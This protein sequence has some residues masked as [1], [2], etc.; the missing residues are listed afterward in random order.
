MYV[1]DDSVD[2]METQPPSDMEVEES[3]VRDSTPIVPNPLPS[4]GSPAR[5]TRR[6]PRA[7]RSSRADAPATDPMYRWPGLPESS[8]RRELRCWCFTAWLNGEVTDPRAF[9][10]KVED[11]I[12]QF[13]ACG[14]VTYAVMGVETCPDTQ[15]LHIQGYAE[16]ETGMRLSQ[17][18][19][20][21]DPILGQG[22]HWGERYSNQ[23]ACVE[24][25][26]KDGVYFEKGTPTRQGR[27]KAA[28]RMMDIVRGGGNMRDVLSMPD[29]SGHAW[30]QYSKGIERAMF[31]MQAPRNP[32]QSTTVIIVWGP[33][34]S[35]KSRWAFGINGVSTVGYRP[36]FF[37]GDM[38]A[39]SL[40]FDDFNPTTMEREVFLRL[41]DRYPCPAEVKGG[42][43]T[44]NARNVI[45]TSNHDPN[46]WSWHNAGCSFDDA[47]RRR[48]TKIVNLFETPMTDE[49]KKELDE[50]LK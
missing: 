4:T 43:V 47:C 35:G 19:R 14:Q 45:F 23:R 9:T 34:G 28:D 48:C 41:C 30:C 7:R 20:R 18:K 38:T 1:S 32:E 17:L 16:F 33:T 3:P 6:R 21:F 11:C 31:L 50:L 37:I 5:G 44:V 8:P 25:C 36:P 26:K 24:Y 12:N 40:L 29:L 49:L 42:T 15:R 2:S 46:T 27:D 22:T 13:F 10:D 39:T